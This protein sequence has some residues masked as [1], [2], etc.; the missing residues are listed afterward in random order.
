MNNNMKP[1]MSPFITPDL[2]PSSNKSPAENVN[3]EIQKNNQETIQRLKLTEGKIQT[4]EGFIP[5]PNI[6]SNNYPSGRTIFIPKNVIPGVVPPSSYNKGWGTGMPC[7]GPHCGPSPVPTMSGMQQNMF[8]ASEMSQLA[9]KQFPPSLREG[10]STDTIK[11][12]NMYLTGT[13]NNP[14]PYRLKVSD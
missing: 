2:V 13:P 7:N 6:N 8:Y 3:E 5:Y 11:D 12:Y 9:S 10:N 4:L 1:G 14:G